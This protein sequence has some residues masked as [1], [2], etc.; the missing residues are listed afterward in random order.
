MYLQ[1][2]KNS[3]S[4]VVHCYVNLVI[5]GA[6]IKMSELSGACLKLVILMLEWLLS[7]LIQWL[8]TERASGLMTGLAERVS[9]QIV[10][11]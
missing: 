2:K 1:G 11:H 10:V 9:G 4:L 5:V 6:K 8:N 7:S 3:G